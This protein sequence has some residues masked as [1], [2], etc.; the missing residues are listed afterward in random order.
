MKSKHLK[1]EQII[2]IDMKKGYLLILAVVVV[3]FSCNSNNRKNEIRTNDLNEYLET[4]LKD[5]T[6][7]GII[8]YKAEGN[9]DT[10]FIH[11]SA[12]RGY[13][14]EINEETLFEIGSVTKTFTS[15]LIA[16]AVEEGKLY[17][18]EPLKKFLPDS[19]ILPKNATGDITIRQLITHSSGLPY[20]PTNIRTDNL[21][22]QTEDFL[23]YTSTDLCEFLKEY[24]IQGV[25]KDSMI[26]SLVGFGV[27]GYTLEHI[28]QQSFNELVVSKITKPLG[29]TRTGLNY[30]ERPDDNYADGYL[31]ME[32]GNWHRNDS[33]IINYSGGIRSC[34]KDLKTYAMANAGIIETPLYSAMLKMREV[35]L[36]V[37]KSHPVGGY[38]CL[39]WVKKDHYYFHFGGTQ[40]FI[41]FVGFN[42]GKKKIN[43][44]LGNVAYNQLSIP[45]LLEFGISEMK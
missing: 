33:C 40:G 15:L 21:V 42:P 38:R 17:Y 11:G 18:D 12:T 45:W 25:A 22:H 4:Q 20:L 41:A 44:L 36:M 29:M 9:K 14:K 1:I 35:Q 26:Y 27:L 8:Y 6:Y 16:I 7:L 13:N 5:T 19:V 32:N 23:N 24:K 28:Y 3:L 37:P 31:G 39:G 2:K 10:L 43:V 30:P 34:V